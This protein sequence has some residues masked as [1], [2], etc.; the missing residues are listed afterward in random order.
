MKSWLS[1]LESSYILF[2]LPP[3]YKSAGKRAV[4]TPKLY[5]YDTGLLCNLLGIHNMEQ[6]L[7]HDM[8]GAIFENLIVAETAKQYYNEGKSLK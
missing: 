2:S 3:Y 6:L 7:N 1:I 4:R 8:F 5:F